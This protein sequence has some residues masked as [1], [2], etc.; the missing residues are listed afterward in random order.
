MNQIFADLRHGEGIAVI[1]V[2]GDL[3][4]QIVRMMPPHRTNDVILF[5]PSDRE[6]A[7]PFNPLHCGDPRRI[8][9][10]VSGAV[11]AFKRLYDSWGPRLESLMRNAFFVTV[12]QGGTLIS[13]L[14]LLTEEEYRE[15]AISRVA[16]PVVRAFWQH[17]F[18][19]WSKAYRTEAVAAVTNKVQPFLTNRS[20]RAT[21][22]QQGWSLDFR[23]LMDEGKILIVNLSKGRLGEDNANLLGALIVTALQQAAMSRAD[24]PEESR[25]DFYLYVDEFQNFITSSFESILSEARKYRLNLIVSHQYRAQLDDSTA[26]A[27]AGNV[28]SIVAFT[29]GED[30]EWLAATMAKSPGQIQPADLA[31]LPRYTAIVRMLVDGNSTNPFSV[32]TLPPPVIAE[33]RSEIVK[34]CSRRQHSRLVTEAPR[35]NETTR[36]AA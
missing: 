1:N 19:S 15:R 21:V 34:R 10:V 14:R 24:I 20:V 26:N 23:Q 2:H 32:T 35:T 16:D 12:E 11:S 29:V 13:T 17:E 3:A 6:Y 9:H 4:T 8:D 30:S 33:D 18:A 27:I 31:N 22:S 36:I 7:V 28:G 5:D 25:R